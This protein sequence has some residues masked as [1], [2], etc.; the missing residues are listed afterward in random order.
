[1]DLG[2]LEDLVDLMGL[3]QIHLFRY[4]LHQARQVGLADLVALEAM[5]DLV[6]QGDLED[7]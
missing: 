4:F 2:D 6:A 1:M 5:A 3:L 7:P